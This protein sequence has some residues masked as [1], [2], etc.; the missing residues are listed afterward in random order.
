MANK[1]ARQLLYGTRQPMTF[2]NVTYRVLS[3][4]LASF[5]FVLT[6]LAYGV[7]LTLIST[8]WTIKVWWKRFVG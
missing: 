2:G 1:Q 3:L 5:L 6:I 4:L 7:A 8:L